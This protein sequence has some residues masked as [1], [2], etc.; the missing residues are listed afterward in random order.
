MGG[1]NTVE[2]QLITQH[3]KT[4]DNE[5]ELVDIERQKLQLMKEMVAM[6]KAKLML[7]RCMQDAD[8]N[9]VAFIAPP[10]NDTQLPPSSEE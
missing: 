9:G 8:V 5:R 2:S 4:L 3:E 1:N 10:A 6:K 7:Q